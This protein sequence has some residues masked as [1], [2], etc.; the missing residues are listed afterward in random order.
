MAEKLQMDA[1]ESFFGVNS[2]P[3]Q[4]ETV[5]KTI[6]GRTGHELLN[7]RPQIYDRRQVFL[8]NGFVDVRANRSFAIRL[9]NF[10]ASERTLAKNQVLGFANPVPDTF[11]IIH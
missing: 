11:P 9:N 7:P 5:A 10:G 4:S 1:L 6:C 3:P 2:M 8:T